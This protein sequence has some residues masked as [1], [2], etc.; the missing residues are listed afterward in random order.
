M[1]YIDPHVHM[2]SRVTDDYYRMAQM[3][4][5]AISEPAFWAGF[6]RGSAE[7]FRDYFRQLV[8]Y[9]PNRARQHG[10]TARYFGTRG[11]VRGGIAARL[12]TH[13]AGVRRGDRVA[14]SRRP[15]KRVRPRR[16]A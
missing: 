4:C 12:A 15:R 9:E 7:A 16:A 2:V 6:D 5:V 14:R 8:E 11:F 3:G 10:G 1:Y 13:R